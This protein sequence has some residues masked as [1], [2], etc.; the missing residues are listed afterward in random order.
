MK[1]FCILLLC[2]CLAG[3]Q[4][5]A[6]AI[7]TQGKHI[8]SGYGFV[9]AVQA[10]G[11]VKA[12][13]DNTYGQCDTADWKDVVAVS[14]GFYHTL[15]LKCDGT[16]YATGSNELGQCNVEEWKNIVMVAGSFLYSF[17]LTQDGEVLCTYNAP[18]VATTE[19]DKWKDIVWMGTPS[20]DVPCA[21]DKNGTPYAISANLSQIRD[22]V[23]VYESAEEFVYILRTDGTVAYMN[24]EE[25]DPALQE[26]DREPWSDIVALDCNSQKLI[27]V[28]RDGTV[29][30]Y[31]SFDGWND[32]VEFDSGFGVRSDG[33]IMMK[34]D[35]VEDFFTPEQL[36]EIS[37]WKVM[38]EPKTIPTPASK[39]GAP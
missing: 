24:L 37:T 8:S 28:K 7:G 33:S 17:G 32:I 3:Y 12:V 18:S 13:G 9:V 31:L 2:V 34:A 1:K 11:T 39:T 23:Q 36:A 26:L 5:P 22:A 15:G 27:G 21:I 6:Y 16:V 30:G 20:F 14:T 25:E 29:V 4:V 19:M 38:V 10:D 35:L